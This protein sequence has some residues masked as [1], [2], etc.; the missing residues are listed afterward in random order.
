[1]PLM[2]NPLGSSTSSWVI[3]FAGVAKLTQSH[4]GR[5]PYL[6]RQFLAERIQ[7]G[8]GLGFSFVR[9]PNL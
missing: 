1:M 4:S 5:A 7:K 3:R 9:P 2:R 6:G 8:L